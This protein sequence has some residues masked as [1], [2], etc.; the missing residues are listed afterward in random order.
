MLHVYCWQ[1]RCLVEVLQKLFNT[2]RHSAQVLGLFYLLLGLI[3]L[4]RLWDINL[5]DEEPELDRQLR[6]AYSLGEVLEHLVENNLTIE[7]CL[8][9]HVLDFAHV[10]LKTLSWVE[11]PK[12]AA[13]NWFD[14]GIHLIFNLFL[15]CFDW[16][17]NAYYLTLIIIKILFDWCVGPRY[18]HF[19]FSLSF[20]LDGVFGSWHQCFDIWEWFK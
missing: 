7:K 3:A 13:S 11:T 15:S 6:D 1:E 20:I 4:L 16:A 18:L 2:I 17:R 9:I 8:K 10:W 19:G 14:N 12:R 5:I